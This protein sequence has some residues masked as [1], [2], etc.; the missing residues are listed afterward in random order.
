RSGVSAGGRAFDAAAG[1]GGE[2]VGASGGASSHGEYGGEKDDG[3]AQHDDDDGDGDGH[4]RHPLEREID[5]RSPGVADRRA[6]GSRR[7][8]RTMGDVGPRWGAAGGDRGYGVFDAH[9][10]GSGG[11]ETGDAL[12][13]AVGTS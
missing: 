5:W 10:G 9:D 12:A 7:K 11:S 4:R 8:W 6:A 2:A 3:E 1:T 13:G